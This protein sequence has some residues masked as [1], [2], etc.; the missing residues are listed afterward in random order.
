MTSESNYVYGH[1]GAQV[2]MDFWA[3]TRQKKGRV[4]TR[5]SGTSSPMK[6]SSDY[7]GW[8]FCGFGVAGVAGFVEPGAGL[9]AAGRVGA[10]TPDCAL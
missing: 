1:R 8:V 4:M 10:G 5:P 9:V 6:V 3:D 2:R 7:F